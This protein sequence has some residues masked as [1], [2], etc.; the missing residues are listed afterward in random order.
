[1]SNRDIAHTYTKEAGTSA[2]TISALQAAL[3]ALTARVTALEGGGGG[4]GY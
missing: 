3:T 4:G 1:M 2:A